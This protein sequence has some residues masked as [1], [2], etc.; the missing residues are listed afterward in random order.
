[1]R[2]SDLPPVCCRSAHSLIGTARLKLRRRSDSR[3]ANRHRPLRRSAEVR[4]RGGNT[5]A[6]PWPC[7][8]FPLRPCRSVFGP[9]GSSGRIARTMRICWTTRP[10]TTSLQRV[11]CVESRRRG[12]ADPVHTPPKRRPLEGGPMPENGD[13]GSELCHKMRRA[14]LK[15]MIVVLRTCP[16]APS[17]N[18]H[19]VLGPVVTARPGTLPCLSGT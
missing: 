3:P 11:I 8:R 12:E 9:V 13:G 6:A 19:S 16:D 4:E 2:H 10:C 15:N 5:W 18:L 14:L 7:P 1:M 17:R